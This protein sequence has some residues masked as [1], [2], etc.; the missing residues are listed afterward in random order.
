MLWLRLCRCVL[1]LRTFFGVSIDLALVEDPE[2]DYLLL[3]S[4]RERAVAR[5]LQNLGLRESLASGLVEEEVRE[6]CTGFVLGAL[7]LNE[8]LL[9]FGLEH[10]VEEHRV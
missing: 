9:L 10:V 1:L 5:H 2:L 3:L 4:G 8:E 7:F 6:G